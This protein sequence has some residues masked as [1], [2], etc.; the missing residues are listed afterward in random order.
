MKIRGK[1]LW[2]IVIAI[3]LLVVTLMAGCKGADSM[4]AATTTGT[5]D[6]AFEKITI[7][8][9]SGGPYDKGD[10]LIRIITDNKSAKEAIG[11]VDSYDEDRLL[12]VDYRRYFIIAAF[13]GWRSNIYGSFQIQYI[14]QIGNTVIIT[15]TFNDLIQGTIPATFI[16]AYSSQYQTVQLDRSILPKTGTLTFKLLDEAGNERA[17]TVLD[18]VNK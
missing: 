18:I 4:T 11:M 10:A 16:P 13:N 5:T 6:L 17:T 15:A 8:G 3:F 2:N 14:E 1:Y 12:R 9:S 7:S